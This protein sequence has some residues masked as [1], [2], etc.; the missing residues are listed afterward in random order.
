[1]AVQSRNL[2]G[3]FF[4]DPHERIGRSQVNDLKLGICDCLSDSSEVSMNEDSC[5]SYDC[6]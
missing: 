5:T 3:D 4:G 6:S 1:M 2:M